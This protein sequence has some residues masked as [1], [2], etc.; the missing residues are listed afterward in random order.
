[1][2]LMSTYWNFRN[3][4]NDTRVQKAV[5]LTSAIAKEVSPFFIKPNFANGFSAVAGVVHAIYEEEI[6]YID[7][8]FNDS[9]WECFS[10]NALNDL[11]I[12]SL[13]NEPTVILKG[14]STNLV[15]K[16]VTSHGA[17]I[18][19][20]VENNNFIRSIS[21]ETG[22]YV[23]I[24]AILNDFIW[25]KWGST[26]LLLERNKT[27]N[28]PGQDHNVNLTF[29]CDN[30]VTPL[31]SQKA[32][33]IATRFAKAIAVNENRSLMLVGPPGSGKSTMARQI[34][35]ELG[36]RTF[37]VK[38]SEL[39]ESS[40]CLYE[41]VDIIRP[42]VIILDDFD[43]D[44]HSSSLLDVISYIRQ[45]VK[46]LIA[47]ANNSD[48]IDTALLRPGRFDEIEYIDTINKEVIL[49]ILG[50]ECAH[51]F[52]DVKDWP[53]VYIQELKRRLKWL[54]IEEAKDSLVELA[55]RVEKLKSYSC[56]DE[57]AT[58]L[59]VKK[60]QSSAKPKSRAT[61]V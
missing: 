37:R 10:T 7:D 5:R 52:D 57:D 4:F 40:N 34:A 27:L 11:L 41:I 8:Y 13:K 15:A 59:L 2:K 45:N 25:K 56:R 1:M 26:P 17:K 50:A 46:L 9:K 23:Q 60:T 21:Y 36:L 29:V 6:T 22:K 58:N 16:I 39:T 32:T 51:L 24:Q 30:L 3:F 49:D 53:V 12:E 61:K 48:A 20:I 55:S 44:C 54:T 38:I 35:L 43:R 47:T 42:D 31:P 33:E 19:W 18:G 28:G 14:T